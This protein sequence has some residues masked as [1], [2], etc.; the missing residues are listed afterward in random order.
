LGAAFRLEELKALFWNPT[1]AREIDIIVEESR[2]YLLTT[3]VDL[4]SAIGG[5]G[6]FAIVVV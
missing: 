3:C 4:A 6:P 2:I 1:I 5:V